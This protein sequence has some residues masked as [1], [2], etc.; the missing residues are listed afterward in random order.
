MQKSLRTKL[1]LL[2]TGTVL[3]LGGIGQC[4]GDFIFD[5]FIFRAVN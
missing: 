4:F 2:I 1:G 3:V 5:Q